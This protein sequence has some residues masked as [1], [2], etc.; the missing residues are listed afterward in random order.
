[1]MKQAARS[2]TGRGIQ[3]SDPHTS[4]RVSVQRKKRIRMQYDPQHQISPSPLHKLHCWPH[5]TI[6]CG[7]LPFEQLL[8]KHSLH[9]KTGVR[10]RSTAASFSARFL[11]LFPSSAPPHHS[12]QNGG[13]MFCLVPVPLIPEYSRTA[14][15][16]LSF[17]HKCPSHPCPLPT[18]TVTDSY[19]SLPSIPAD[20]RK[21][22]NRERERVRKGKRQRQSAHVSVM[23]RATYCQRR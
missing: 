6:L 7:P 11:M 14:S 4:G 13:R 15:Y 9:P 22:R 16:T 3:G 19:S 23:Q 10:S 8:P 17:C 5:A 21:A 2:T 12:C 20:C 18:P 1:M